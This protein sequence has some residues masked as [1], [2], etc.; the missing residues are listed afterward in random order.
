MSRRQVKRLMAEKAALIEALEE[1]ITSENACCFS[2]T[3]QHPEWMVARLWCISALARAAV[4]KAKGT[5]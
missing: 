2:N 1:C 4:S 3:K 5:P